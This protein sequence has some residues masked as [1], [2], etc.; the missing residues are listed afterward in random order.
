MYNKKNIVMKDIG[1]DYS[2]LLSQV[3][4]TKQTNE[5]ASTIKAQGIW[6]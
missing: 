3:V 6:E 1:K 2:K 4:K 5:E